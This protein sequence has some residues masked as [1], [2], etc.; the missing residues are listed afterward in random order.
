MYISDDTFRDFMH[1]D[2]QLRKLKIGAFSGDFHNQLEDIVQ[3]LINLNQLVIF[4]NYSDL[5]VD[6]DLEL[7]RLR[8]LQ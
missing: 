1:N 5:S 4:Q 7:V 6:S 8:H 3:H 2:P